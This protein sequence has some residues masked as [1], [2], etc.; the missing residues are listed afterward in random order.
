MGLNPRPW[1]FPG[2]TG[3]EK[4]VEQL[5]GEQGELTPPHIPSLSRNT[6]SASDLPGS[7]F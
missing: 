5:Q 3:V 2:G 6:G 1:S 4:S 7:D